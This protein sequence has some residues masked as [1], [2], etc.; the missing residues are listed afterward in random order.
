MQTAVSS[1]NEPFCD[2]APNLVFLGLNNA[3]SLLTLAFSPSEIVL[4]LP[5]ELVVE[6]KDVDKKIMLKGCCLLK[7]LK[8]NISVLWSALVFHV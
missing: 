6:L 7:D 3:S 8:L 1:L 5:F 4:Q 2:V